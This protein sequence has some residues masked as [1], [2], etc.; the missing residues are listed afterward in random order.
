MAKRKA[1]AKTFSVNP[2]DV[3]FFKENAGSVVGQ[4]ALGALKLARAEKLASDRGYS[5]EWEHDPD[6]DLSWADDRERKSIREV[7]CARLVSPDGQTEESLCGI[8]D[9]GRKYARVVEA[10]LAL[11]HFSSKGLVGARRRRFARRR[12]RR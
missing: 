1:K 2:K 11:E 7:L 12:R 8:V 10:E 9:P 3:T 6:P 4:R 5:V